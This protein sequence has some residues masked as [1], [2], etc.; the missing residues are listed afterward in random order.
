MRSWEGDPSP[1]A[2]PDRHARVGVEIAVVVA[3][4][5]AVMVGVEI[6]VAVA[7]QLAVAGQGP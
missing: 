7:V 1:H 5:I 6:A 2:S 4:E 3:V